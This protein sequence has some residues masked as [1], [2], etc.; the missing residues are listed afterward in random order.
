MSKPLIFLVGP[1][2]NGKEVASININKAFIYGRR[3]REAGCLV[4]IPHF[5]H[6]W[7]IVMPS[8]DEEWTEYG[9]EIISTC[10]GLFL[11]PDWVTSSG[12]RSDVEFARR[13]GKPLFEDLDVL[14]RWAFQFTR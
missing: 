14:K 12:A 6:F 8:P 10:N 5:H 2:N 13:I 7:D 1:I 9:H 3:I 4:Y 11:M